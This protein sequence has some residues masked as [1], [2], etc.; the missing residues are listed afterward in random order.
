MSSRGGEP[1]LSRNSD[2]APAV[3]VLLLLAAAP[4]AAQETQFDPQISFG[5]FRT[6]N[7]EFVGDGPSDSG[8]RLGLV[9]PV[10]RPLKNG[11]LA[12]SYRTGFQ[13][14]D[15]SSSLNNLSH[16]L[17]LVVSKSPT[18]RS[19]FGVQA[20]Y[21]LTQEQGRADSLEEA[22]LFLS[23]RTERE[24]ANLAFSFTSTI[25]T[26]WEWG[27]SAGYWDWRFDPI[28]DFES[29]TP[30][31]RL[32]DRS[33]LLGSVTFARIL[34]Q[35]SALGFSLAYRQFDLEFSGEQE[36]QS[37]SLV[38][39][40]DLEGR[41]SLSLSAGGFVS[42]GKA[43]EG[44]GGSSSES[45]SGFQ[46][47]LSYGRS[48]KR[49]SVS[50]S[51]G[52]APSAGNDR[53]GTSVNTTLGVS[54][55]SQLTKRWNWGVFTRYALRDPNARNE[56]SVASFALGSSAGVRFRSSLSIHL[57]LNYTDQFGENP[58]DEGSFVGAQVSLVW[59]PLARTRWAR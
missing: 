56:P 30:T 7:V 14:F 27:L 53:P 51:A 31:T 50:I 11:S 5:L 21:T 35:T 59:H 23:Q 17:S 52:H 8:F 40:R 58:A 10:T 2:T 18:R 43:L 47:T 13:S 20:G 22:D 28:E 45:R 34:S 48:L 33:E 15:N 32:E 12:F 1:C 9:L 3:I 55:S 36:T 25:A 6:S 26:R 57:G 41:S 38:Y 24:A 46:G 29:D 42:T 49:M 4:A 39:R 44:I 37:A 16:R 19:S 54:I